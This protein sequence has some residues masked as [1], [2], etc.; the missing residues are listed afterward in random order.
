MR[1]S[2]VPILV[3]AALALPLAAE[4]ADRE[5]SPPDAKMY[6]IWPHDGR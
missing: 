1:R 5:P 6:I 2:A 3:A 4:A